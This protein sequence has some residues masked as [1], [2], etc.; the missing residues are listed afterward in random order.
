MSGVI[1]SSQSKSFSVM[2]LYPM[3]FFFRLRFIIHGADLFMQG[4]CLLVQKPVNPFAE[5]LCT[6]QVHFRIFIAIARNAAAG[7]FKQDTLEI[8]SAVIRIMNGI[9]NCQISYIIVLQWAGNL[10]LKCLMPHTNAIQIDKPFSRAQP[11]LNI[12]PVDE[13]G[14]GRLS[15]PITER[16]IHA[17]HHP[18]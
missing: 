15:L 3:Y 11:V 8:L 13:D 1:R 17:Y 4:F 9:D 14:Q 16:G 2:P 5:I 12:I 18:A 7:P 10:I 6:S